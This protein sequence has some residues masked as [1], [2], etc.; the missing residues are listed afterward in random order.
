MLKK[1]PHSPREA[2]NYYANKKRITILRF[3]EDPVL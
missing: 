3:N 2:I 1:S